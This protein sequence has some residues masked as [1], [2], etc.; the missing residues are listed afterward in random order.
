[1]FTLKMEA[2]LE[3]AIRNE[4]RYHN[5][6]IVKVTPEIV[7]SL[8]QPNIADIR[9]Q[10]TD[11]YEVQNILN[12]FPYQEPSPDA[13]GNT[14]SLA[15]THPIV[16]GLFNTDLPLPKPV[17]LYF[18]NPITHQ[19]VRLEYD[20]IN[21]IFDLLGAIKTYYYDLFNNDVVQL[22]QILGVNDALDQLDLHQDGYLVRLY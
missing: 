4:L 10:F 16:N 6:D 2:D 18:D 5:N 7:F 12:L 20:N 14:E 17:V 15:A 21:T 1:M 22:R 8:E 3:R 9:Y 11:T 19:R 13:Y